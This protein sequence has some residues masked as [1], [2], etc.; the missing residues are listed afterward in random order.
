LNLIKKLNIKKDM[1]RQRIFI[2]KS[3][4]II[5]KLVILSAF[6]LL[7]NFCSQRTDYSPKILI[8]F[9]ERLTALVT[10]TVR[11]NLRENFTKQNLLREKLPFLEKK[12]TFSELMEELKITEHL[13]DIAYLIEADLMFELQKPENWNWRENYNSLEVQKEIFNATMAGI[14]QALSQLKGE[15]DGK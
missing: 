9:S 7:F 13:K 2:K 5:L 4:P 8:G 15:R 11:S 10:T 3:I 1:N 6:F 14:K 12:T